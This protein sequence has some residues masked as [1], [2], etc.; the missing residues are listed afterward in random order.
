MKDRRN[1]TNRRAAVLLVVLFIVMAITIL[2][3]GFLSRSDVELA[4]GQNMVLRTRTDYLA[5][6]GL[7]HARGLILNPQ[8]IGSEYWTGGSR[9]QLAAGSDDYYD[10]NVVQLSQ[11]NYQITCEAYK[12][13]GDE[14]IGRSSLTGQLRLDPCIAL[15]SGTDTTLFDTMIINGDV[16]CN[17]ALTNNST[18]VGYVF[19]NTLLGIGSK[20]GQKKTIA[21]LSL[22]WPRVTV[23]D[24][25]CQY[26]TVSIAGSVSGQ[27]FGPYSPVRVCHR[28]GDLELGGDATIDGM[29]MVE[30][31]LRIKG[32]GN[33]VTAGKNLPA[34]LVTGDLIIQN[35]G[36]LNVN[37]L[38]VVEGKMRIN[39]GTT[40]VSI[41]GGLFV[42]GGIVQTA[43]DSSGNGNTGTLY[44]NPSWRPSG[45]QIAGA[46]EFDGVDDRVED[47]GAG[48]YLNG[49]SAVTMSLW[50]KSD[51]TG[52]NRGIVF[53][54]D[55]TGSDEQLGLRY[56][57]SG[58][59]GGGVKGIKASIRTTLGY[60][61]IES[62]SNVQTTSWQHLAIV[63]QSGS[64]LKL[65]INGQ[66]DPL[67][68]DMGPI[69]GTISGVQKF[70]LGLGAKGSYWDGMVDDVRI[71]NRVLDANEIYPIPSENG[72]LTH[73]KLDE[74]DSSSTNITAA[75]SK[76]AIVLW[77]EEGVAEK[78]AQAVGAF[79]K[80]IR[81][82]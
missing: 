34:L 73:W 8:D 77:S 35:G 7:E 59:Y 39:A 21:D 47:S 24:F 1:K 74:Q 5:E 9:Q 37:G 72:L 61:Q 78:W 79:F 16:Y 63:W 26:P 29:L 66:L 54:S 46:L 81:R 15:W 80:S 71:Y 55:P 76:T 82:Q 23:S 69:S 32:N 19:S 75:P 52:Q 50:V 3:L 28:N 53:G 36:Q 18:I 60:R 20:T 14:K 25:S 68:Y 45:G 58:I 70:M 11:C 4:C 33:I 40:S 17:G 67:N 49:L 43:E 22:Q 65:Y 30:G 12:E 31:N 13:K 2:S 57:K 51:V 62:T 42:E 10:V 56:D 6:S 38:A 64:S 44:N 41:F 48:S 27:T